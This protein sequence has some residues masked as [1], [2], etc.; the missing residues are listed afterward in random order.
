MTNDMQLKKHV[1]E[2]LTWEPSVN[3]A[4]VGIVVKDA[5]VTLTGYVGSYAEKHAAERAVTRIRGVKALASEVEVRLPGS[6]ERSDEDIARAAANAITWNASVPTGKVTVRVSKG[7][8]T[9]EGAVEWHYQ[10]AAAER[11]VRDLLGI[12]GVT[13]SIEVNP[14]PTSVGVKTQ[15]EAA[16]TRNAELDAKAITVE[17]QGTKIILRGSAHSWSG[18]SAAERAAWAAPG[19]TG[20]ENKIQVGLAAGAAW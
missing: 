6:M 15:I 17:T 3:A 8:V 5:V 2:E 12:K 4:T 14:M 16:L 1:E 11:S 19:V 9:L 18:R 7:W 20:V 10:R 13:N